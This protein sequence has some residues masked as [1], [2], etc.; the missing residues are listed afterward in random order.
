MRILSAH[1]GISDVSR[2]MRRVHDMLV[3]VLRNDFT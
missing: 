1:L 3:A 2:H